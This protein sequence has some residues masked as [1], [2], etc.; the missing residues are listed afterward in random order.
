MPQGNPEET[1]PAEQ[2]YLQ[3]RGRTLPVSVV[4]KAGSMRTSTAST[5]HFSRPPTTTLKSV[6][7]RRFQT[8]CMAAH[9]IQHMFSQL[10]TF[11]EEK[12]ESNAGKGETLQMDSNISC[13]FADILSIFDK[14]RRFSQ[15]CTPLAWTD[16]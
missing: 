5:P 10:Y 16:G 15:I 8:A 14:K 9:P 13:Y 7:I 1:G 12:D 3:N 11:Q 2:R 6:G 4:R